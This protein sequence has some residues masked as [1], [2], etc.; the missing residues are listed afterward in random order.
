M[1]VVTIGKLVVVN[2][3][4]PCDTFNT[5][6][7]TGKFQSEEL[8]E[9]IELFKVKDFPF[10]CWISKEYV[11][12]RSLELLREADLQCQAEE[13]GMILDLNQYDPV[14]SDKHQNIKQATTPEMILEFSQVIAANWTP[15]DPEV[16][17]FYKKTAQNFLINADR[18]SLLTYY[19]DNNPVATVEVFA[20]NQRVIGIHGL[21]TLED[22]RGQ[23]IGSALM[24]R[25]LNDAKAQ[26]YHQAVLLA[27]VDGAGI[28][29]KLG[30]QPVTTYYEYA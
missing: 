29:Q 11:N 23:G 13:A 15:P 17:T 5:I 16:I 6:H 26:G 20:T 27:T 18:V 1:E 25:V 22:T 28:Y 4:L 3:G 14:S 30:F 8:A 19:Q 24:T 9:A 12:D 21:A 2:S 10:C 7:A